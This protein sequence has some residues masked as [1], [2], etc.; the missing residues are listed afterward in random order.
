MFNK[1]KEI[2][3]GNIYGSWNTYWLIKRHINSDI[4]HINNASVL[5]HFTLHCRIQI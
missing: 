2:Q 3:H 4:L 1:T 5:C